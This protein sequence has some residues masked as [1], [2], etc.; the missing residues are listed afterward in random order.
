MPMASI[1]VQNSIPW[2]QSRSQ[3]IPGCGVK[4]KGFDDLS[5]GPLRSRMPVMLGGEC[6]VIRGEHHEYKQDLEPDGRRR[7]EID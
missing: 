6:V 1:C 5:C 2:I 7:E 3:D 4:M